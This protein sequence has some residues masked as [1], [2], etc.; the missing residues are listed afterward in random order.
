MKLYEIL[1]DLLLLFLNGRGK[2]IPILDQQTK[3]SKI[4]FTFL[5]TKKMLQRQN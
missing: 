3:K 2:K 5:S 4:C 1:T